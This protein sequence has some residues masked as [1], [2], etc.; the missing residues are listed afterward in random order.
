MAYRQPFS[1]GVPAP[2][3]KKAPAGKYPENFNKK[4]DLKLVNLAKLKPWIAR[5][6]TEIVGFEDEVLIGYVNGECDVAP[7]SNPS[8]LSPLRNGIAPIACCS[9][10]QVCS[11]TRL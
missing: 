10:R 5:R 11:I 1:R 3:V 2:A 7:R 4:V 8:V 9:R 6:I